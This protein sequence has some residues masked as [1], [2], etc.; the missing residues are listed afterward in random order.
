MCSVNQNKKI[1]RSEYHE[2]NSN[3]GIAVGV[4]S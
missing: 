4:G 1:K 3:L 2:K